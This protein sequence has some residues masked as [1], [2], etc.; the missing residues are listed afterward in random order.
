MKLWTEKYA[1]T[2]GFE[3]PQEEIDRLKEAILNKQAIFLSGPTGSCKTSAVYAIAKE[4]N[5]E[6]LELN[7]S[8][9]RDKN[10]IENVIGNAGQQQSLFSAG[11]IILIDELEGLSGNEDRGGLA[12]VEKILETCKWPIVITSSEEEN[13]DWKTLK[14]NTTQVVFK[15]VEHEPLVNILKR[16][17][18]KEK[19]QFE[20][21]HIKTL[22]RRVN[23]DLRAGINDL[24]TSS[25][26]DNKVD[27]N[28]VEE[29]TFEET[30]TNILRV[31]L[32]GKE[33]K[34]SLRMFDSSP[35]TLDECFHWIEE[36][37][38]LEYKNPKDLA[39]AFD[40]LSKADVFK[41]RIRK[42]QHW[43]YL[44]YQN[45]LMSAGVSLAKEK[46]YP[47]VSVYQKPM[48][49]LLIWK[50]NMKAGKKKSISEKFAKQCHL[51]KRRAM[52]FFP[53]YK[54]ILQSTNAQKELKLNEEERSWLKS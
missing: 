14:K 31:I 8:D 50:A 51:S 25:I 11:K 19:I 22:A 46:K 33:A 49:G 39:A 38:P 54:A 28:N 30:I 52:Q 47:T 12:T 17:C 43:H 27:L 53:Q 6:V 35:L 7:A 15:Q 26:F 36:N 10:S 16:I 45:A 3:I 48:F 42:Q 2:S 29:R 18:I 21:V 9:N 4:L 13:Y 34:L 24:Y 40:M 32:K 44:V 23:G 1:P 41:G 20:D 5:Y 37:L